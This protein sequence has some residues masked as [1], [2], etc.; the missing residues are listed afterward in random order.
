MHTTQSLESKLLSG[1][2]STRN[3]NI[4]PFLSHASL[5]ISLILLDLSCPDMSPQLV[6][7]FCS[8]PTLQPCSRRQIPCQV[9][10]ISPFFSDSSSQKQA[11]N[12]AQCLSVN[13]ESECAYYTLYFYGSF[14]FIAYLRGRYK[15]F[16]YIPCLHI[17]AASPI[18]NTSHQMVYL[19]PRKSLH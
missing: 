7:I 12:Q 2:S 1:F 18:I 14:K 11:Q 9:L 3:L 5:C 15:G 8:L 17:C 16:P 4:V 10:N 13:P 6:S 19:L